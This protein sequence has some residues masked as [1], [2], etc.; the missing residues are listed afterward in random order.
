MNV[1]R[2]ASAL[3]AGLVFG[4]GLA[5]AGMTNP[6]KVLNFLDVTRHWDPSLGL[7]MAAAVPVSAAAFWLAKRRGRPFF[8][9][10][11]AIPANRRLERPLW[12]GSA[13]FGI[14]WGLA[15]YCPGPAIASL[16]QPSAGLLAFLVALG[17]G[18]LLSGRAAGL[19]SGAGLRRRGEPSGRVGSTTAPPGGEARFN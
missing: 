16:S 2:I 18:L 19:L 1:A 6:N 15:G 13:L 10:A 17:A 4:A 3:A 8:E 7:V 14:G 12:L 11:F 9:T 5:L